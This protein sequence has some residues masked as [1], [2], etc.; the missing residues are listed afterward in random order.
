MEVRSR[1]PRD[2]GCEQVDQGWS[3]IAQLCGCNM[4]E[5]LAGGLARY[6]TSLTLHRSVSDL[7]CA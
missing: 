2:V 3:R 1:E 6:L 4:S 7:A 5:G